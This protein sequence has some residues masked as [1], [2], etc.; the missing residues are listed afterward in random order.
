PGVTSAYCSAVLARTTA[1]ML[2][3]SLAAL[4]LFAASTSEAERTHTVRPGQ[5]LAQIARRYRVEVDDLAAANRLR[6]TSTLRPG[7][8]LSVPSAG[9][10]YVRPGDSLT[11]L[12]ARHRVTVDELRRTNRLR[13]T[14][15]RVGQKLILPGHAP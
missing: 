3:L 8:E 14:A 11:E 15:L 6:R 7:Q 9:E 10:I 4:V 5:T 1:S 2:A 12:A 13:G